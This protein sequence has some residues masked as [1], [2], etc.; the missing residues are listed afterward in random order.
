MVPI[1]HA[2]FLALKAQKNVQDQ[3][4]QPPPTDQI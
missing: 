2:K 1:V 4:T 3:Q